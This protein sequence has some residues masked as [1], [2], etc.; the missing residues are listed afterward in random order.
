MGGAAQVVVLMVGRTAAGASG[1]AEGTQWVEALW[2]IYVGVSGPL[3]ALVV[4]QQ[5]GMAVAHALARREVAVAGQ[6]AAAAAAD[7]GPAAKTDGE[8][9]TLPHQPP[10]QSGQPDGRQQ[11]Q[12]GNNNIGNANNTSNGNA[13]VLPTGAGAMAA[14]ANAAEPRLPLTAPPPAPPAVAPQ[15]QPLLLPHLAADVA[16]LLALLTLT[17]VS[18]AYAHQDR[19]PAGNPR[20]MWWI[21]I[22]LGP[23]GAVLR[24]YLSRFNAVPASW[25]GCSRGCGLGFGGSSSCG[26]SGSGSSGSGKVGGGEGSWAWLQLG[27]FVANLAACCLNFTAEAILFRQGGSMTDLQLQKLSA[28]SPNGAGAAAYK[29]GAVSVITPVVLGLLAYG[30]PAWTAPRP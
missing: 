7:A 26:G 21:A 15:P 2:A 9:S 16:A 11:P 28:A 17:G 5:A 12:P 22:L 19:E 10:Q 6:P 1:A 29:Y 4:G 23:P 25:R 14:A 27:T 3:V 24:W 8:A 13:I 20:R 30:V 18:A